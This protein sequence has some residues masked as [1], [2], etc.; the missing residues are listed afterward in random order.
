MEQMDIIYSKGT[1]EIAQS[2][3]SQI[4][5]HHAADDNMKKFIY[6]MAETQ[7]MF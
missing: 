1:E 3:M 5:A 4:P 7:A 6:V 2:M